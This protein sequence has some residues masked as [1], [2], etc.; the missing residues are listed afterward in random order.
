MS[1]SYRLTQ[2][3]SSNASTNNN[4]IV[5]NLFIVVSQL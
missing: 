3:V 4:P 2:L 5:V 1:R